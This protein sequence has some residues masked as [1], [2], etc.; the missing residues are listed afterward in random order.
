[1]NTTIASLQFAFFF[2][3]LV[4]RPDIDFFDINVRMV[5]IFDAMPTTTP[6][7]KE[8]PPDIPMIYHRSESGE[9]M[10][11]IARS[12]LDFFVQRTSDEKLNSEIFKDF[13]IKVQILCEYIFRKKEIVRFGIIGRCFIQDKSAIQSLKKRYFNNRLP[14]VSELGL[15]FNSQ[16]EYLGF[17]INEISEISSSFYIE[18]AGN[19]KMGI[20]IQRDI[21]NEPSDKNR[22]TVDSLK[23][24]SEKYSDFM[25]EAKITEFVK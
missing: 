15:R 22:L 16:S 12:R 11:N 18:P 14:N 9:F 8:L 2:K 20:F 5:N 10:C 17:K 3:D 7:P 19:Q 13:N 21:N 24:I 25:S 23:K 6:I 4:E 1:M